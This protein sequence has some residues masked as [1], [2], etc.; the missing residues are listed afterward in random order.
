MFGA[1][2]FTKHADI[3]QYKYSGYGIG[4]DRHGRFSFP[5]IR[6]GRNV[7]IFGGDMSSSPRIDNKKKD[8][9]ILGKGPAQGLEHTVAA[10]KLY[11]INF[12][13]SNNKFCLSLRYNGANNCLFVN[14]TE[15][16][17][18]KTKDSEIVA[19]PLCLVN[20]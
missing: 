8:I 15:V 13:E 1:V 9:L 3:D 16:I 4:F 7:I 18:F 14:G 17:K 20:I 12:T 19:T 10:E 5:G 6:F 11:L 2:S